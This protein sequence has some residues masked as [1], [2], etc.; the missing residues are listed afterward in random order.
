MKVSLASVENNAVFQIKDLSTGYYL[1]NAG[2]LDDAVSVG[3]DT[4]GRRRIQDN[5]RFN[6]RRRRIYAD[7][8]Y[9]LSN[10]YGLPG[11]EF[12]TAYLF[13]RIRSITSL[14][15]PLP[16]ETFVT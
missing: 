10:T 16:A 6:T 13:L 12:P 15:Q 11:I 14:T 7:R 4:S 5:C 2:E 9:T 3:G 8:D 1:N